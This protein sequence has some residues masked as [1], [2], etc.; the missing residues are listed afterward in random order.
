MMAM[1]LLPFLGCFVAMAQASYNVSYTEG[2]EAAEGKYFLYN[3]GAKAFLADGMDW[4]AHAT[5]DHAGRVVTL[6]AVS[7]EPV[8]FSLFT[9]SYTSKDKAG[10][11][12]LNGYLDSGTNDANWQFSPVTLDGYVNAYVVKHSDDKVLHYNAAD[13]RVNVG[14]ST[15]DK[16]SYWLLV[17]MEAR[18]A[19][20][21]YT[22]LLQNPDFNRPWERVIWTM[23]V[24]FTNQSG[25]S[26]AN[27]CAE[28]YHKEFVMSQTIS[29]E[30]VVPNGKYALY[31][32]GFFNET[33]EPAY[34]YANESKSAFKKFNANGEGTAANMGG[35]SASFTAGHYV[36]SV[37]VVVT[38]NSLK[39]GVENTNDGN[40]VIFDNFF[41]SYL[42][43]TLFSDAEVF[44]NGS[45]LEAGKWYRFD[46]ALSS[47][48]TIQA[49]S[50]TDIVYTTDGSV[51]TAEAASSVSSQFAASQTLEGSYFFKSATKQSLN[52]APK[53]AS[54][55]VG[56][57][58]SAIDGT[59]VQNVEEV[60]ITFADAASNDS[61]AVLALLANDAAATLKKGAEVIATSKLSVE[62]NTLVAAFA[63]A[64][65]ENSAAYT[66]EV[67]ADVFGYAGKA[68]N[69]AVT[70]EFNTPS[71]FDGL[72]YLYNVGS[73]T[74][75]S[76]G[77]AYGTQAAMDNFGLALNVVT[78]KEG[79]TTFKYFDN[80]QYLG[81]DNPCYADTDGGRMRSY[82]VTAV[83]GGY[84]LQNT[85]NQKYLAVADGAAIGNA[86]DGAAN[87]VWKFETS[88]QHVANY[89]AQVDAQAA[90]VAVAAGLEGI[91]TAVALEEALAQYG[92]A[93]VAIAGASGEK[94]QAYSGH[95][96]AGA[97]ASY[98]KETINDLTPGIYKL[99]VEAF[100]RATWN[101]V[102]AAADGA[103]GAVYVYAGNAKTQVKSVME[104]GADVAY[105]DD[106]SYNGKHYPNNIPSAQK[107]LAT[108][109]YTN[110]VYVYV[111]DEGEGKGSLTIGMENPNWA[112]NIGTWVYYADYKLTRY[113]AGKAT[114]AEIE[115][116]ETALA[117]A[118]AYPFGFAKDEYAPYTNVEAV[119]VIAAAKAL[120]VN[121]A[122]SEEVKKATADLVAL[123]TYEWTVNTEEMNAIYD[124]SFEYAYSTNGNVQPIAWHGIN[125][126]DNA[127]DIR[128]M[129]NVG[130]DAGLAATSTDKALF[131]KYNA[132]YGTEVGYTMPLKENTKY[133]LTF[134]YGGWSDCQ[135]DG[136]VTITGPNDEVI[137][138]S[139]DRLPLDA[140]D[141]HANPASW[142]TYTAT[143]TTG[144]AGN[145]V[146]GLR[147]NRETEGKQSQYVYGDFKLYAVAAEEPVVDPNDYTSYIK[148]ADLATG[149]AWNT[150]GTKGIN[151]GYVKVGSE[152]AFDFCQTITLPAGQYKMTAKAAYRYGNSEQ[153]EYNAIKA[154]TETHLVKL[155]AETSSY[156][157]E[158]D[159]M[160]RYEG[161]S[162]VNYAP[163]S[164]TVSEVNGL[165]VPNASDAVKAWFDADQYI[166]EIVFNV[167]EVGEVKIGITRVGG[168]AGDYTNIGAWT[169]T[170]L[171][172]AEADPE[173]EP[174]YLT[175]VGAKAGE[176]AIVEGAATVESISSFEITFDRPV[177]LAEDADW[178]T[179]TDK[180]GDTS[181]KAEVL[182]DNNHVVRF[183]LQWDVFTEAGDYYLYI[184][185]G[186]V[187]GAEDANYINAAIEAV[188]TIEGGSVEP[189]TPLAVV[190]VTVGKD[191]MEGL[192]VVATTEDM[193]KVNFDGKFYFQGSPVVVDADGKEA[194]MAFEYMNG[195]DF[196]GSDSYILMGKEVGTYT[197]TLP[198]AQ[199]NELEMMGWKAPAEDIVLKVTISVPDGIQNINADAD[200][201]IYDI[202]GRRVE[203]MTK[204]LYIVNGKKVLVK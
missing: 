184:P 151:N 111:A 53:T 165:F 118:E 82:V 125:N 24:G 152:S 173:V 130:K 47:D 76:R 108:D 115:A 60:V 96:G 153:D 36:N 98:H 99:T 92:I 113:V 54:Y 182:E 157:Y 26:D 176:V 119:K 194:P 57:A 102:V 67:P 65:L 144:A 48:F 4:G 63:D 160:N 72:Y 7:N 181:L 71:L 51:L 86:E 193:I 148:N 162:D 109:N 100:Q 121:A 106:F 169:L 25:G 128:Y 133:E 30:S 88:A 112:N 124:G 164:L 141:G 161:A 97:P 74:Y 27:R 11:M 87:T 163:V 15:S 77:K 49:N 170:R 195:L 29:G 50:L 145:Y 107:A 203:K 75:L 180:W 104:Y 84:K 192:T 135:K 28:M 177:A 122:A 78:N 43:T 20:K 62:G 1:F 16:N 90:A 188:I 132:F 8:A 198:K 91:T 93:N 137:E 81:D 10:Y 129:W 66:I 174:Q 172:D 73:G 175:V 21:D 179:L 5:A 191:V 34:L 146:L 89:T 64:K 32:Q 131:T 46:V 126:H 110:V 52:F 12:T 2:V 155:Y 134:I 101:D 127:T 42:G 114:A 37:E 167:Q 23:N 59:Y 105:E 143:F 45:E 183:S 6:A 178:A 123:E 190:N 147:T 186:V 85:N 94:Y 116:F 40:W 38:D 18:V 120:D 142:K 159:V 58:S 158:T 166:N 14:N 136:Y 31:N 95:D 55:V 56:K 35:A 187:V 80:R 139:A 22:F 199:F 17:P 83:E 202:H 33:D 69:E 70:I 103:R 140:V 150:D 149:D 201:V 189:A 185:E 19:A 156:K 171:G 61:E 9:E 168:I 138:L 68:T 44:V 39:V 197:I 79:K 154:G 204:G 13:M 41:L 200:A 196:D 117:A 3:I